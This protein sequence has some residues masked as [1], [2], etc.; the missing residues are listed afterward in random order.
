MSDYPNYL[1]HYGILGQVHGKRRF[2]YE[3]GTLTP[4]GRER[5]GVGPPR[6]DKGKPAA[7]VSITRSGQTVQ[8]VET[9]KGSR[10]PVKVL[11]KA[12][13]IGSADYETIKKY[14]S[15]LSDSEF[16]RA[17]NRLRLDKQLEEF[18]PVP[19]DAAKKQGKS[20]IAKT[21]GDLGATVVKSTITGIGAG[22][23]AGATA[24]T[25]R[26]ISKLIT[27]AFDADTAK[28]VFKT[29]DDKGGK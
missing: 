7:R 11:T 3:D 24:V 21:L 15:Q 25:K 19:A 20:F 22:V 8:A 5:Y 16:S 13:V 9:K 28:Q 2:Q 29:G 18:K 10:E 26:Q 17:I 14:R 4:E 6:D 27:K 1:S 12:E 23:M